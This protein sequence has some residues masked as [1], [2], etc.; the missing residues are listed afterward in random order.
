MSCIL[1]AIIRGCGTIYRVP[2]F[3]TGELSE[4]E[5]NKGY[6][7]ETGLVQVTEL[8]DYA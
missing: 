6:E 2:G 7:M 4:V 3:R 1:T 5:K 8:T